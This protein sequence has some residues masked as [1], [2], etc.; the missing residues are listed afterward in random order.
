ML[1]HG[2]GV[3]TGDDGK[4]WGID[5]GASYTTIV[6][7]FNIYKIYINTNKYIYDIICK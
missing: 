3:L 1:F 4:V 6:N 5:S 7:I 2:C